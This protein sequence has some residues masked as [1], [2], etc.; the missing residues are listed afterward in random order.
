V[1]GRNKHTHLINN[2]DNLI[3]KNSPQ[4]LH[5]N[6]FLVRRK[7]LFSSFT[8]EDPTSEPDVLPEVAQNNEPEVALNNEPE[9]AVKALSDDSRISGAPPHAT[10][11]DANTIL[12]RPP[13]QE[14]DPDSFAHSREPLP[15]TP[16]S[17]YRHDDYQRRDDDPVPQEVLDQ[18]HVEG[19]EV[20]LAPFWKS[21]RT[22]GTETEATD[23]PPFS[24]DKS[25]KGP[26]EF[27]ALHV[28][29]NSVLFG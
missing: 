19:E 12:N 5:R 18:Y 23:W 15:V 10:S 21:G 7:R 25:D 17:Y 6:L 4:S 14:D 1:S 8:N 2:N 13:T 3:N 16:P 20:N 28:Q 27:G 24:D 11:P 22:P 9:V 29:I 26:G